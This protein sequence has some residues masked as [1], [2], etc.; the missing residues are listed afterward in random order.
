MAT[1]N[2]LIFSSNN[3]VTHTWMYLYGVQPVCLFIITVANT[4]H[5]DGGDCAGRI[6]TTVLLTLRK[7]SRQVV[8]VLAGHKEK[9]V[10]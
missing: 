7:I 5:R 6:K 2:L 9:M 1:A 3:L 4:S 10:S 8:V